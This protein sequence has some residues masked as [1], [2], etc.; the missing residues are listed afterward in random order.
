MPEPG[1]F[2]WGT[3]SGGVPPFILSTTAQA[4]KLGTNA[5]LQTAGSAD[6]SSTEIYEEIWFYIVVAGAVL[7]CCCLVVLVCRA[8][9]DTG[10][11]APRGP[12]ECSPYTCR[13]M[14][15]L[16]GSIGAVTSGRWSPSQ[17]FEVFHLLANNPPCCEF[18]NNVRRAASYRVISREAF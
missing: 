6:D 9:R 12:R 3:G 18:G 1:T 8:H 10:G 11:S 5:R 15:R 2:I 16:L 13:P 14:Y 17:A 7:V 4:S